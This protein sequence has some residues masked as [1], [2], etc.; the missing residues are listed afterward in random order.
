MKKLPPKPLVSFP[1]SIHRAHEVIRN[2]SDAYEELRA[3]YDYE[4]GG[5]ENDQWRED[6][7]L[8]ALTGQ[9]AIVLNKLSGGSIIPT[10]RLAQAIKV[11]DSEALVPLNQIKVVIHR[12]RVKI[13]AY[14]A[15]IK[16][17][18]SVGYQ[19]H[20]LDAARENA[21]NGI[22]VG[23][24]VPAIRLTQTDEKLRSAIVKLLQDHGS[25]SCADIIKAL[26][27]EWNAHFRS[28]VAVVSQWLN[29]QKDISF[30]REKI[31][32]HWTKLWYLRHT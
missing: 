30:S 26:P 8:F 1:M 7:L 15:E 19:V 2:L 28:K 21:R 13:G 32:F 6:A 4:H 22:A 11:E 12:I 5:P 27:F 24:Y 14:G 16:H 25:L 18:T 10:E 29:R 20:G 17:R 23:R 31:G 3:L 9:E